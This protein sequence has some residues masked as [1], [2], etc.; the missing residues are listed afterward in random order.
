MDVHEGRGGR[1]GGFRVLGWGVEGGKGVLDGEGEGGKV[2][3][4]ERWDGKGPR[5]RVV[6]REGRGG[7]RR[8]GFDFGYLHRVV[9]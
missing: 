5:G 2:G 3:E 6:L 8:D 4:S 7:K 9:D 1:A